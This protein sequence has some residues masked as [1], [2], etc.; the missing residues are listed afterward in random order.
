MKPILIVGL[1]NPGEKY[2]ATRHNIGFLVLDA[3]AQSLGASWSENKKANALVCEM[4]RDGRKVVLAK[5]QTFMNNSGSAVASLAQQFDIDACDTWVVYD[6]AALPFGL[7]RIRLEGSAGGH[8]GIKSMI[9]SL[10]AQD[11]VRFRIGVSEPPEHMA[12]EDWVLSRFSKQEQETLTEL[13]PNI[14]QRLV[15]A[16][17]DGLESVTENLME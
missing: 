10:G 15:R 4:N 17:D 11:F 5:P 6:E 12:L 7:L 8:N 16:L 3:L 14:A 2:A 1:G 13:I 9:S